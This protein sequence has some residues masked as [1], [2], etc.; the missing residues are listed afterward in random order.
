MARNVLNTRCT[1]RC[2][3][4]ASAAAGAARFHPPLS[5]RPLSRVSRHGLLD[6]T[7][8][9]TAQRRKAGIDTRTRPEY[10]EPAAFR[11]A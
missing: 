11:H 6:G 8:N 10:D 7:A 2:D 3:H 5:P 9:V 1:L 4:L